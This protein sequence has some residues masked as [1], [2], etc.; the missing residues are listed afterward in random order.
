MKAFLREHNFAT[1]HWSRHSVVTGEQQV[2][3]CKSNRFILYR[4][5]Y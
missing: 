1:T 2:R 3:A 4:P 5:L